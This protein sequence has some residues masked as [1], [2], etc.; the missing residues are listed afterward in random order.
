[1]K[2][3]KKNLRLPQPEE[4]SSR[5]YFPQ[6]QGSPVIPPDIGL[7]LFIYRRLIGIKLTDI[8]A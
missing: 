7:V 4:P 5:I 8:T 6:E 3:L 2:E 1:M